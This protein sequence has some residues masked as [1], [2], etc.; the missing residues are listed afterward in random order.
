MRDYS[1]PK[2]LSTPPSSLLPY[3][4][5]KLVMTAQCPVVGLVC[6]EVVLVFPAKVVVNRIADGRL[7]R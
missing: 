2:L 5:L 6:N 4:P 7:N 1:Y 3:K